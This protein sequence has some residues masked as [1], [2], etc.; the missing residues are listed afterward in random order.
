MAQLIQRLQRLRREG[1]LKL[2]IGTWCSVTCMR[3]G[4]FTIASW[5]AKCENTKRHREFGIYRYHGVASWVNTHGHTQEVYPERSLTL[6]PVRR[7]GFNCTQADLHSQNHRF[8]LS[9]VTLNSLPQVEVIGGSEMLFTPEGT[10]LYDELALGC[11]SRYGA[12]VFEII[13]HNYF[14]PYLPAAT[15]EFLLCLFYRED[16]LKSIPRAISLLK[17]H[18]RNYYHWL[19]ECLPRATLALRRHDWADAPLL[20][21]A[22]LPAQFIESLRLLSSARK[23]IA[24]PRGLRVSVQEL[25]F[26]SVMSPTHDYYGSSPRAE[27]F[28]IAPEAVALLRESLLPH[29]STDA[30][31]QTQHLIYVARSGGSHRSLLNESEVISALEKMGFTIVYP[32][33]LSFAEQI[34]LFANAKIIVGP[35]GAA[36]A[37]IVF[38]NPECKIVVLAPVT[39][40][41]NFYLFAQIA[42]YLN[43]EIIYVGGEP[44]VP[45]DLHSSF[46][47]D[48]H[49]MQM[50]MKEL[51]VAR[52]SA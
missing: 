11:S 4:M 28:L 42:Q 21:D 44:S 52:E 14:H 30:S 48:I 43:Q 36:M 5:S 9:S 29:V 7:V 31:E 8:M 32:G 18:S 17:D 2:A 39:R 46:H 13:P 26:P 37:N 45:S 12:K 34:V 50:L 23:H 22:D 20:I 16:N 1:R 47:I 24:I 15:K 49:V 19:L 27:D 6:R 40:N 51:V 3:L 25:Y 41:A 38:A 33:N 10:V 35:T